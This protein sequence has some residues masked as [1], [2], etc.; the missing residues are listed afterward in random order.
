[1]LRKINLE[2]VIVFGLMIL[3][4][5]VIAFALTSSTNI[6]IAS[7]IEEIA[8]TCASTCTSSG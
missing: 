8:G 6:I 7:N 2:M 4:L 1:M 5:A 3:F